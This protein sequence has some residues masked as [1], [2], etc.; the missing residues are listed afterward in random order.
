MR[1]RSKMKTPTQLK[2]KD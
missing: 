2:V 1:A